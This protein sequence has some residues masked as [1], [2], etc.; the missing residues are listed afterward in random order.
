M[1]EQTSLSV[2]LIIYLYENN[3][4]IVFEANDSGMQIYVKKMD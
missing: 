1:S 2:D 4:K 3:L